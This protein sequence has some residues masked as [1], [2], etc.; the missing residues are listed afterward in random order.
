MDG[1][2][3]LKTQTLML[4]K[5]LCAYTSHCELVYVT[6]FSNFQRFSKTWKGKTFGKETQIII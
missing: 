5:D 2:H 6:G 3:L 4:N 1:I